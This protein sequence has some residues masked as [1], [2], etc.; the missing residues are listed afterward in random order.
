MRCG[1]EVY[2]ETEDYVALGSQAFRK[3]IKQKISGL[4]GD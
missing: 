1:D 3:G 2:E 4:K